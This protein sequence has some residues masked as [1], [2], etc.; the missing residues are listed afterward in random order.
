MSEPSCG[1]EG[2]QG[3]AVTSSDDVIRAAADY[4]AVAEALQYL[5]DGDPRDCEDIPGYAAL[6]DRRVD[7]LAR[8]CAERAMDMPGLIA[9][10]RVLAFRSAL[11]GADADPLARGLAADL[12]AIAGR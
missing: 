8:L 7:A 9:K 2:G 12:L 6:D 4:L 1:P 11:A 3:S 5:L 10:A